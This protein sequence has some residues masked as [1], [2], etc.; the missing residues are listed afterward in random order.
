[1]PVSLVV[2]SAGN[3]VGDFAHV[4]VDGQPV[5]PNLVGYNLVVVDPASGAV[6]SRAAFNTFASESESAR[7]A[8]FIAQIPEGKVVAVAVRDEASRHLTSEAVEALRSIGALQDLRKKFRWSHAIMGV[9]GAPPGTAMESAFETRP[10]ELVVGLAATEP[11]V[12]AA[13][14]WVQVLPGE[15]NPSSR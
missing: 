11:N 2:S 7:L 4:Y 15:P 10:A 13:V 14:D 12:A 6:E 8:Q 9:K 5:S 1:V 3:E